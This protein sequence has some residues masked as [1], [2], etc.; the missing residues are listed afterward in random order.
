MDKGGL[1]RAGMWIGISERVL[2]LTF[3]IAGQ[4]TALGFLMTAKSIL[5]FADKEDN[6]QKKTEYVLVGTLISF[7]S[8]AIVGMFVSYLLKNY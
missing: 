6:T 1:P 4:F 3:I 5:R 8:A 7:V 2:A